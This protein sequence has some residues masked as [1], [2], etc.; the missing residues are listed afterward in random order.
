MQLVHRS[1]KY[2]PKSPVTRHINLH[3]VLSY[4]PLLK[5]LVSFSDIVNKS[6]LVGKTTKK[7]GFSERIFVCYQNNCCTVTVT[8]SQQSNYSN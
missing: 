4:I 2:R 3:F 8:K 6:G 1:A 7:T 5:L